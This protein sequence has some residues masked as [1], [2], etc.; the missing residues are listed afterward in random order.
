MT[1]EES[2]T[3]AELV[4]RDTE[5]REKNSDE[6]LVNYLL[7]NPDLLASAITKTPD[8]RYY[9]DLKQEL[10]RRRLR[11]DV[12]ALEAG[13]TVSEDSWLPANLDCLDLKPLEPTLLGRD[14]GLFLLYPGRT[15][16]ISGESGSGKSWVAQWAA[17]CAL[18]DGGWVLYLDYESNA[19]AVVARLRALGCQD[20]QLKQLV[21]V[22][23]DA[24][25][26]GRGFE[27]LL[28]QKYDLAVV[29]GVTEA[30]ALSG[31][32]GDNL[33]NSNDA[34]TRWHA[35]LPKRLAVETG[36]AVL[37]VDHVTK[38]KDGRGGYAIGGQAKRAS[39][40]GAAYVVVPRERFGRG[41]SGSLDIY[42]S[43]DREGFVLG[44]LTG[45]E[46]GPGTLV[47][48]LTVT[49]GEGEQVDLALLAPSPTRLTDHND[50]LMGRVADFLTALPEDHEGA[51]TSTIRREVKG[52][53]EQVVEALTTLVEQGYV[54]RRTKGQSMLH[55]L[56]KSYVFEAVDQ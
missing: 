39:I 24:A 23:P 4:R 38:S 34:V 31:M 28:S 12:D 10:N 51:S 54:T 18:C 48:Q 47:G 36:A 9:I 53:G 52:N 30:L 55:K 44:A 40:T 29:D 35:S 15:H 50:Q 43:K 6:F 27:A 20:W 8:P 17:A 19:A 45:D 49:C 13:E 32:T 37:Q 22:N 3:T 41:R 16:S 11:A 1:T 46:G 56:A 21:Y 2:I 33:T 14:D 25:P 5:F 7:R 42:V 26:E